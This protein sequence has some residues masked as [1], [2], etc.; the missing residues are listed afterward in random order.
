MIRPLPLAAALA[1]VCSVPAY[2]SGLRCGTRLVSDGNHPSEVLLKCGE[3]LDKQART[4]LV[5]VRLSDTEERVY[6][7]TIEEWTYNFGPHRLLQTVVF[8][9]GRVV[10]VRSGSYG[11]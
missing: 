10:D 5:K 1:L 3:P 4:E 8:E 6:V 11:S 7:K 9:D 2:A